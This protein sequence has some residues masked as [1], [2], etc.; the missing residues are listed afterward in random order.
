M[1]EDL[2]L[3]ALEND[4]QIFVQKKNKTKYIRSE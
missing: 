4:D 2:L 3:K 1:E